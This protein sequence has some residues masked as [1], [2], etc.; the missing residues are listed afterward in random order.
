MKRRPKPA[1]GLLSSIDGVAST[2]CTFRQLCSRPAAGSAPN[3]PAAS[4]L[5]PTFLGEVIMYGVAGSS[6]QPTG[7]PAF[8]AFGWIQ[9]G[10]DRKV[11]IADLHQDCENFD[12]MVGGIVIIDGVK[13]VC[14]AVHAF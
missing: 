7:P 3:E 10:P 2:R 8:H 5:A 6:G 12:D 1:T 9:R 11:A 13:Y 14:F 4:V